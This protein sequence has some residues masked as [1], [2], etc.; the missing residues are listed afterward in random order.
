[1]KY[2]LFRYS[3][4]KLFL[5]DKV[6]ELI[7]KH[8]SNYMTYIE[9]F[10]G[11]GAI[12]YNLSNFSG[13]CDYF[14]SDINRDIVSMHSA[15]S[16]NFYY[17]YKAALYKVS[18]FGDIKENKEAYYN[19]RNWWNIEY[20]KKYDKKDYGL[21]LLPLANSCINSMLRFG[22][23]GMNQGFGHRH[24]AIDEETY[25]HCKSRLEVANI[26]CCDYKDLLK[27]DYAKQ[28]KTVFFFDPPYESR[29]MTYNAGFN[30][31]EF[32]Q[33]L[34]AIDNEDSLLMY[35]DIE[36]EESDIL[37]QHGWQ[38]E[39]VRT[40]RTTSPSGSSEITGNEVIYYKKIEET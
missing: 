21:Y 20:F 11:S 32:L 18:Q 37:L 22:P 24:Y 35:T 26:I 38:K 25:R 19:Y 31:K 16:R 23:K 10:I 14:L 6:N 40:M 4:N 36:N 2:R 9:P 29:Q 27:N 3:G 33:Q 12:F 15:V 30:R 8:Q 17:N 5:V 13:F 34:L 7:E 28:K 39:I 1:M